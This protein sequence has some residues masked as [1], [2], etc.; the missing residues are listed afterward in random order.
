MVRKSSIIAFFIILLP[1]AQIL[2]KIG[3]GSIR[4]ISSYYDEIFGICSVIYV[5]LNIRNRQFREERK[6]CILM[7]F[8]ISI[9]ILSNV[10][11][12]ITTNLIPIS[13]DLIELCKPIFSY[14]AV[15]IYANEY[16]YDLLEF[17]EKFAKISVLICF[18]ASM[19][20]ELTSIGVTGSKF[21]GPLKTFVFIFGNHVHTGYFIIGCLLII[22]SNVEQVKEYQYFLGVSLVPLFLTGSSTIWCWI[23]IYVVLNNIFTVTNRIRIWHLLMV[24]SVLLYFFYDE[25]AY[26]F[27][28]ETAPRAVLI[29]YAIITAVAYFPL[30]AGFATYGSEMAKRYY[31]KLYIKYGWTNRWGLDRMRGQY[32]NDNFFASICGQFGFIGFCLYG[33]VLK[34]IFVQCNASKINY[35]VRAGNVATVVMLM[36]AMI[37]SASVKTA[38]GAFL[39]S[40]LGIVS[41]QGDECLE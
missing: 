18:F 37:G 8:I 15:R 22:I 4:S 1:I 10:F 9:G 27:I 28:S 30:G 38:V 11:H 14:L 24:A 39:F 21:W 31:S 16:K 17:L 7:F 5:L 2:S 19:I 33:L 40:I 26:Y 23:A 13:I 20:G 12:R 29:R 3:G 41:V 32:L 6:I 25:F 35:R 36:I 34:N